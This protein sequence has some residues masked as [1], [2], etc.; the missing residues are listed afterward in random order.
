MERL[1]VAST[2]LPVSLDG[3]FVRLRPITRADYTFLWQCR[4][5]PEVMHLWTQGRTM[6]SFEQ[7]AQELEAG[8]SGHIVT[9]LLIET[10]AE[11]RPVGFVVAYDYSLDDRYAFF[12]ITLAPAYADLGWGAEAL[13]L[14]L[15]YLFAF[16]DL[17]KVCMDVFDFNQHAVALLLRHGARQEGRFREQRYYQGKFHD[18][19]RL[20][21]MQE[22]WAVARDVLAEML[23]PPAPDA[24]SQPEDA[25]EAVETLT[26]RA[27]EAVGG[28]EDVLPD[29]K[30]KAEGNGARVARATNRRAKTQDG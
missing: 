12:N 5:R 2:V 10:T 16:F 30:R 21:L 18:V 24:G 9:L 3:R 8:L 15:N 20:G 7:Y 27:G 29:E 4:W 1:N 17:R 28:F 6:P 14:F 22:E 19:I 26:E 23:A 25:G 13:L 11:Q